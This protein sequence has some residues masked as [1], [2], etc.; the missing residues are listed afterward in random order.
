MLLKYLPMDSALLT[1]ARDLMTPEQL[2]EA[3]VVGPDTPHGRWSHT[4]MLLALLVDQVA[5]DRFEKSD[6]KGPAPKPIRRPGVSEKPVDPKHLE[7]L[8]VLRANR[9]G[10]PGG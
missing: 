7:M 8:D 3:S 5:L 1:A 10:I 2:A 6:R 9:G 4:N